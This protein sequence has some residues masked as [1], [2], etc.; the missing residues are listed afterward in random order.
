ML[1]S[2][3][4]NLKP[5][6]SLGIDKQLSSRTSLGFQPKSVNRRPNPAF[7][8]SRSSR[9]MHKTSI[10]DYPKSIHD[11]PKEILTETPLMCESIHTRKYLGKNMKITQAK[12][13]KS[14][15]PWMLPYNQRSDSLLNLAYRAKESGSSPDGWVAIQP[16][17]YILRWEYFFYFRQRALRREHEIRLSPKNITL[18]KASVSRS[19]ST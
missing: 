10:H 19:A 4:W 16:Y 11:Y 2:K 15:Q 9:K 6:K 3:T 14:T 13:R 12:R 18:D 1:C 8:R 17:I 5:T 7:E